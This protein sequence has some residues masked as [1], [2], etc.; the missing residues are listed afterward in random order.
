MVIGR[1]H[2]FIIL[3]FSPT[4]S[5]LFSLFF[6]F[7]FFFFSLP[8]EKTRW[9]PFV[10][11]CETFVFCRL[12]P[13]SLSQIGRHIPTPR[14][15]DPS[16]SRPKIPRPPPPLGRPRSLQRQSKRAVATIYL[17]TYLFLFLFFYSLPNFIFLFYPLLHILRNSTTQSIIAAKA[18]FEFL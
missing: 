16:L 10:L 17:L 4:P 9:K 8:C 18:F 12:G 1:H 13:G 15:P 2:I 6:P 3:F 7:F 11:G 5:T 14:H